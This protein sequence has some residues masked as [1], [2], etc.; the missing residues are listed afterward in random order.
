[1]VGWC[2]ANPTK[3]KTKNGV[4]RFINGWLAK[5]QRENKATD[6]R[7]APKNRFCNYGQRDI[8]YDD[9]LNKMSRSDY[10]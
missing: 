9:L 1:M 5:T 6:A 4:K 2:K 8:D 7:A 3:R 10:G